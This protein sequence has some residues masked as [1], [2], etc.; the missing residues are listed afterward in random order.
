MAPPGGDASVSLWIKALVCSR[1]N[2]ALRTFPRANRVPAAYSFW[3]LVLEW[4]LQW[5]WSGP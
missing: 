2:R 4:S 3:S 1:T 5:F